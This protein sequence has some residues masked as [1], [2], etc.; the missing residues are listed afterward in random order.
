MMHVSEVPLIDWN[1]YAA[2]LGQFVRTSVL[3]TSEDEV[4][5]AAGEVLALVDGRMVPVR[6]LVEVA[7]LHQ[8]NSSIY[9][10]W[11]WEYGNRIRAY[12]RQLPPLVYEALY[13]YANQYGDLHVTYQE[14]QEAIKSALDAAEL[15]A[16]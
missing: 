5:G 10:A 1:M 15:M 7:Q 9:E 3:S 11:S 8:W 2:Q 14:A 16:A 6:R 12:R 4:R 13:A